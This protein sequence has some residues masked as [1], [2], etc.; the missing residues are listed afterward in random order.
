MALLALFTHWPAPPTFIDPF[1][2]PPPPPPASSGGLRL[3]RRTAAPPF[4][5]HGRAPPTLLDPSSPPPRRR[6]RPGLMALNMSPNITANEGGG[7][8]LAGCGV[9]AADEGRERRPV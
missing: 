4:S 5:P 6:R 7:G 2:S 8:A 3:R 9:E 1:H